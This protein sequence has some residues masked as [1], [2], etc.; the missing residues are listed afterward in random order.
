[1]I[2]LLSYTVFLL[3]CCCFLSYKY[4]FLRPLLFSYSIYLFYLSIL[5]IYLLTYSTYLFY[6]PILSTYSIYLFYLPILPTYFTYLFYLPIL[7]FS[8]TSASGSPSGLSLLSPTCYHT[9][10]SFRCLSFRRPP[11][12]ISTAQISCISVA[13]ISSRK[14][15]FPSDQL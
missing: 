1:M 11:L 12:H 10:M 7:S 6:L 3:C 13:A 5:L 15:R 2:V 14:H 4:L 8:S 9:R